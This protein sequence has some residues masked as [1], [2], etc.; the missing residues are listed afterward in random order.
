MWKAGVLEL[1]SLGALEVLPVQNVHVVKY[2][3]Y[4]CQLVVVLRSLAP[5]GYD[6]VVVAAHADSN[7]FFQNA[8]DGG[9]QKTSL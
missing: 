2:Q 3:Y 8:V 7:P 6:S 5:V 1:Y 9:V 4:H